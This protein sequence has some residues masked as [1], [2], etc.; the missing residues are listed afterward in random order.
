M[1]I[2]KNGI[3][4]DYDAF[5]NL[6][7]CDAFGRVKNDAMLQK[8]ND[9]KILGMAYLQNSEISLDFLLDQDP[10]HCDACTMIFPI[11]FNIWHGLELLLK[12]GNMICDEY[13]SLKNQKYT[14]HTIDVYADQFIEKMNRLGFPNIKN[15][16]LAGVVEFIDECKEHDAH[17]DFARYSFQSNGVSQFYNT[18]NESGLI[19]RVGVDM[20][21]LSRVLVSVNYKFVTVVD[22]LFDM[23][24]RHGKEKINLINEDSLKLYIEY[25]SFDKFIVDL[26]FESLGEKLEKIKNKNNIKT[27]IIEK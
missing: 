18:P 24:N 21:E 10:Y 4:H 14:K 16:E 6:F 19:S 26:D 15:D 5:M 1:A 2:F 12:C 17:F 13:L 11:L 3:K 7:F 8:I 23:L 9:F 20:L 22:F 27:T 25:E